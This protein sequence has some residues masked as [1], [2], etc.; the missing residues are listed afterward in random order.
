MTLKRI[1]SHRLDE[2][3]TPLIIYSTTTFIYC[4]KTFHK[5]LILAEIRHDNEYVNRSH[6]W[7]KIVVC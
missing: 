3:S 6:E 7:L 2:E 1:C 4:F 5:A